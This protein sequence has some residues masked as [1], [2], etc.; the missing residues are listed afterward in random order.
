MLVRGVQGLAGL[1]RHRVVLM[2][3]AVAQDE[4][5][6]V[7]GLNGE[8]GQGGLRIR[9]FHMDVGAQYDLVGAGDGAQVA[10]FRARH[11]GHR[12]AVIEPDRHLHPHGD[13]A[14]DTLHEPHEMRSVADRHEVG[15]QNL[16]LPGDVPRL[17]HEATRPVGPMG[18]DVLRLRE[19]LPE[20]VRLGP[21]QAGEQGSRIEARPAQ[22]V[23]AAQSA[24]Q[25]RAATIADERVIFDACS[26][27]APA[28]A[29]GRKPGPSAATHLGRRSDRSRGLFS[30]AWR[31][32]VRAGQSAQ[33]VGHRQRHG[34]P[35]H[36]G[37]SAHELGGVADGTGGRCQGIGHRLCHR[38]GQGIRKR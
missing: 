38:I 27:A 19:D 21:E 5:V 31:R 33:A 37:A 29:S 23:D 32:R 2:G 6:L 4:A 8:F 36:R 35:D 1:D 28:P 24:D 3:R 26:H 18:L 30:P 10:E 22:P 9:P 12:R 17:Q 15:D 7:A 34:A 14:V 25:R 13:A 16:A 11:P 20:T